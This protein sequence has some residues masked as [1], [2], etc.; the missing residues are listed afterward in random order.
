MLD[1]HAARRALC[2]A[3]ATSPTCQS[4]DSMT[5]APAT[6]AEHSAAKTAAARGEPN[7][8]Q[9]DDKN[10]AQG[11]AQAGEHGAKSRAEG[12][13]GAPSKTR[14]RRGEHRR[15]K[16]FR[17]LHDCIIAR[18]YSNTTL[19]DIASQAGM[20]PSHLLYY[21]PGKERI[22]EDYFADVAEWFLQRIED[23]AGQP[24]EDQVE[25]WARLW[26]GHSEA[27][28]E[29]I[30]FML[31]CFGAAV[32]DGA[33]RQTKARF[34]TACKGHLEALFCAERLRAPMSTREAAEISYALLIGLRSS[35]YFDA[36]MSAAIASRCF[37]DAIA[38][39]RGD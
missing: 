36:A 21:F 27:A 32:H 35:V 33:M 24:R 13:S 18:G 3:G 11:A 8:R 16:I 19:G 29:D 31:E 15:R 22:L 39:L 2:A 28:H 30:G 23:I 14:Q 1:E 34:D 12:R 37:G 26:F 5:P 6:L 4:T 10:A 20:S 38:Q 25:L 7:S 9:P 17:A